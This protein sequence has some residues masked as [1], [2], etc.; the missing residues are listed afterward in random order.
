MGLIRIGSLEIFFNIF[1]RRIAKSKEVG[2]ALEE[3]WKELE[4]DGS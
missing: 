2:K 1:W 3:K 4:K